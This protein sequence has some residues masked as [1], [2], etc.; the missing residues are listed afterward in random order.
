MQAPARPA[1]GSM[2]E[3]RSLDRRYIARA[4]CRLLVSVSVSAMIVEAEIFPPCELLRLPFQYSTKKVFLP[5][6]LSYC[7]SLVS[8]PTAAS[9]SPQTPV[10]TSVPLS[11]RR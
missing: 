1:T 9:V 10:T 7:S 6:A 2:R 8:S 5:S 4:F 3:L 11:W